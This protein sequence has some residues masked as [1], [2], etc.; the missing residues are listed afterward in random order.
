MVC[1]CN[2][3]SF[4]TR[5]YSWAVEHASIT[6]DTFTTS[7]CIARIT[8]HSAPTWK[9]TSTGA[10]IATLSHMLVCT[11]GGGTSMQSSSSTVTTHDMCMQS[12]LEVTHSMS[13]CSTRHLKPLSCG[14]RFMR[15]T[16]YV[17]WTRN[18]SS[19][20]FGSL[21]ITCNSTHTYME[22]SSYRLNNN[23]IK[24]PYHHV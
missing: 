14:S 23:N 18:V 3:N 12:S 22:G 17:A 20:S 16:S 24:W 21:A 10:W 19:S 7:S 8:R 5:L 15:Q 2:C 4:R 6:Q 1:I 11:G 9:T 13:R